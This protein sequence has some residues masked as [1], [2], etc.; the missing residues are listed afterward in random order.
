MVP[1]AKLLQA[2]LFHHKM[3]CA[4]MHINAPTYFIGFSTSC[5]LIAP[6]ISIALYQLMLVSIHPWYKQQNCFKQ[7]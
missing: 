4:I 1:A 3:N 2:M 5:L 7:F 6:M